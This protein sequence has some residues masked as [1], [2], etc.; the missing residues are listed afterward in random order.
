MCKDGVVIIVRVVTRVIIRVVG[1]L[2]GGER[3]VMWL[4]QARGQYR[5]QTFGSCYYGS[6][7]KLGVVRREICAAYPG[8]N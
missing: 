2:F 3:E 5:V 7:T 1:L 4:W 8:G 6:F